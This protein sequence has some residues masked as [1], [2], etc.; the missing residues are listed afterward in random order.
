MVSAP[1]RGTGWDECR[2]LSALI[3][4]WMWHQAHTHKQSMNTKLFSGKV[5]GLI[6]RKVLLRCADQF[7]HRFVNI[8]FVLVI[9]KDKLTDLW[10]S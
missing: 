9:V 2:H 4:F 1:L 5:G 6:S 7:P 10:R 8:F 3:P